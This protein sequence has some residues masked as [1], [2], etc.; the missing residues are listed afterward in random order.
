MHVEYDCKLS[1]RV[2]IRGFDKAIYDQPCAK[3]HVV[4]TGFGMDLPGGVGVG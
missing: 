2:R 3:L 4:F 1:I